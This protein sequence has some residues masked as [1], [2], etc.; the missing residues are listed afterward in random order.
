MAARSRAASDPCGARAPPP[1]VPRVLVGSRRGQ[2]PAQGAREAAPGPRHQPAP[3]PATLAALTAEPV[4]R[5]RAN[6]AADPQPWPRARSALQPGQRADVL[7]YIRTALTPSVAGWRSRPSPGCD[8]VGR[9]PCARPRTGLPGHGDPAAASYRWVTLSGRAPGRPL[10]LNPIGFVLAIGVTRRYR[11]R[12][13]SSWHPHEPGRRESPGWGQRAGLESD[14]ISV[15][16]RTMLAVLTVTGLFLRWIPAHGLATV[17]PMGLGVVVPG[18]FVGLAPS[19]RAR[20]VGRAMAARPRRSSDWRRWSAWSIGRADPGLRW[21]SDAGRPYLVDATQGRRRC[22]G[23]VLLVAAG[24]DAF[25]G[26]GTDQHGSRPADRMA[27]MITGRPARN[28]R[29]SE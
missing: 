6:G 17:V 14:R 11:S 8:R 3:S 9:A 12:S 4:G 2:A 13:R 7:A 28:L 18:S 22:R 21:G 1:D 15:G 16:G 10:P 26:S 20:S 19:A 24:L 23:S 25:H 5:L 29:R 27:T